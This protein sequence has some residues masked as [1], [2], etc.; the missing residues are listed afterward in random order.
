MSTYMAALLDPQLAGNGAQ[1]S[2]RA[3]W[4]RLEANYDLGWTVQTEAEWLEGEL[5]LEH[6]GEIWGG[7]TAIVLAPQRRAGVAVLVNLGSSRAGA[8]AR[9]ILRS[10]DGSPLP[11]PERMDRGEIPDTWAVIF[12][13]AAAGVFLATLGRGPFVWRQVRHGTRAWQPT[14]WRVA[15]SAVLTGL[16]I[17]LLDGLLWGTDPP[18]AALPSTV[19]TS[20]PA[21]VASVTGLLLLTAVTGL[22]PKRK[23]Q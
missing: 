5:V 15:R 18:R 17:A 23:R 8:V 2:P 14:G 20:L 13:A 4:E 21:L 1:Y 16:A 7:S 11:R 9:A 12:L 6:T 3:W 22:V 10:R 19:R